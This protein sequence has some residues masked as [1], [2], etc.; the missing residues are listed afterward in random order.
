MTHGRDHTQII[1][2]TKYNSCKTS[3]DQ[4]LGS[5]SRINRGVSRAHEERSNRLRCVEGLIVRKVLW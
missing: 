2:A 1:H 5:K 4:R 3:G